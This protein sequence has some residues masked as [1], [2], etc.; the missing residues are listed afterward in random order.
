MKDQGILIVISG[1]SATGKGTICKEILK[2]YQD[3]AYSISATTRQPRPGEIHGVNYWFTP[4]EKFQEMIAAEELL[5]WAE[6]YGNYYGTP[7]KHVLEMLNSG[8]DVI[9]EIDPQG[10]LQVKK[11]FPQGLFIFIVPP[12]LAELEKRIHMRD[13][14]SEE[15]I[16]QR[17]A[18]AVEEIKSAVNYDYVV[19]NDFVEQAVQK[20]VTILQAEYCNVAR[21]KQLLKKLIEIGER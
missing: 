2:N 4:K 19:V 18:A 5:E 14:D 9:L 15:S 16:R 17:M 20:I 1:P 12:S 6:V 3:L 7:L 13:A 10:A 11:K 21:N 8:K